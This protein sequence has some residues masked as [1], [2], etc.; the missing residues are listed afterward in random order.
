MKDWSDLASGRV[1]LPSEHLAPSR[2]CGCKAL[3]RAVGEH[4]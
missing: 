3:M 2:D 4:E 1:N